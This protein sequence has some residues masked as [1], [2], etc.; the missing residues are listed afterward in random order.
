MAFEERRFRDALG[1]FPTGVGIITALV[2]GEKLGMTVSS[3]NSLSLDPP[4]ILFSIYRKA[5][6][7]MAWR[8]AKHFAVNILNADQEELSNRFA[9]TKG[10]KWSGVTTTT[11]MTGAPILPGAVITFE[12]EAFGRHDGG[13]HEIFVGRVIALHESEAQ[14][15]RSL[16]FFDGQYRR[17]SEQ[18]AHNVPKDSHLQGWT[19]DWEGLGWA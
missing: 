3:F 16:V 17:L 1:Q 19:S 7:F 5:L 12:C 2:D 18:G 11:G 15:G 4:L 14:C 9:R 8:Q 10:D 6:S 13:D